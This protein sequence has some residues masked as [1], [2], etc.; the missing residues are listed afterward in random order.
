MKA[1]VTGG[2][3][4]IG[5]SLV[6]RLLQRGDEVVAY[7]NLSTGI[8]EFLSEARKS[9]KFSFV[10]GDVL[11][12]TTLT[13]AMSGMDIVFH[14]AANADVRFGTRHPRKDLEQNTIATHNVLEA[15]RAN[16]IKKIV[17][18]STGSVYGEAAVIPTPEACP[19]PV[20]TSL[21]AASKLAGEGL[22]SAYCEG[23]GFQGWIFRFVSILGERYTHGHVFDFYKSLLDNPG[24]LP[25][26]GDGKQRK[27]Y[28]YIQDCISAM[29]T[30]L[31]RARDNVNVFNLGTDQYCEVNDSIGWITESLG[32]SPQRVYAGGD[33]GWVGDN[34]FIFLDTTKIRSLGWAPAL[35]IREAVLRTLTYLEANRWVLERRSS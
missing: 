24:Q 29:F 4:F 18:S 25:V 28:L 7:D 26:L 35:T 1:F 31:Q 27:S 9:A 11:D 12:E 32:L 2:A 15:M 6:D 30:A 23:F 13:R 16:G 20:Q 19:F 8:D 14:L 21:Y 5:S 33:R 10:Q 17:F 34:P 3:G 22:I